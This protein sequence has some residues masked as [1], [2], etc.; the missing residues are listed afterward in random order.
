M[1]VFTTDSADLRPSGQKSGTSF[2]TPA[3]YSV[4]SDAIALRLDEQH[5]ESQDDKSS[6]VAARWLKGA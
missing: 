3:L 6:L 2:N 4:N 5:Y 1:I